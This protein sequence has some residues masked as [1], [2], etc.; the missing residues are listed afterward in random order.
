MG[1]PKVMIV[2]V[3]P[4][5]QNCSVLWDDDTK[6]AVVVDP[7]GDVPVILDAVKQ[8]GVKVQEIWL[9]H[10]HIDHAGGAAELA[11]AL[12]VAV[13]G[14]SHEDMFLLERLPETGASYGMAGAR[15]VVPQKWLSQGDE[16]KV[17]GLSFEVRHAPGHTPGHVIFFN[18]EHRFAIVGDVIFQGSIGRTDL[19]GGSHET[20]LKSIAEQVMTLGDDVAFLCGHGQPSQVGIERETNPFLQG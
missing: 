9:T 2:P 12:G 4:F 1:I 14:P 7:G 18:A 5:Q 17:G 15:K 6:Q 19:P 20:L 3:T 16:V 13:L 11:E 8:A 10:G